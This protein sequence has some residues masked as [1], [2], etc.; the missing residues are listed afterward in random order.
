MVQAATV[1]VGSLGFDAEDILGIL[2]VGDAHVYILAQLRHGFPGL[3]SGPEL[4]PVIEVAGDFT[5]V[6]LGG[7][8][9][10]PTGGHHVFP[11]S[12]S[13]AGEMEPFGSL[14]DGIPVKFLRLG[15]LDGGVGPVVD[16]HGTPL[17]STLF[18]EVNAH[19]VAAAEDF[20]GI[21]TVAPQR[22]HRRLTNGV[23]RK[24]GDV[25]RIQPKICQGHRHVGLAAAEG[26]FHMVALDE[27]L[28]VVGLKPEH[29]LTEGNDFCHRLLSFRR[30][31]GF[32]AQLRDFF[33]V[34]GSNIRL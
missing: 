1:D 8:T 2:L 16:A 19:P 24:L 9:G 11:Q 28:I 4:A 5:A 12:R 10:I 7:L 31:P 26:E 15:L 6:G 17:G 33:P 34:A 13:N 23:G 27:P 20:G 30:F 25:G 14:K 18:I 29:Q 32:Q 3:V 22:V 21:H